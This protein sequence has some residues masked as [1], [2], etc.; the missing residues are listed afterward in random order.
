MG[1]NFEFYNFKTERLHSF[2]WTRKTDTLISTEEMMLIQNIFWVQNDSFSFLN[3][4]NTKY[5]W[6]ILE[7]VILRQEVGMRLFKGI[8]IFC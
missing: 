6:I 7:E 2:S 1:A 3:K 5:Y 4:K 8:K